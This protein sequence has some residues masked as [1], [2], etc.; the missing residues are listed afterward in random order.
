MFE[1]LETASILLL[2]HHF[3]FN[4]TKR[5]ISYVSSAPEHE[6]EWV[7]VAAEQGSIPGVEQLAVNHADGA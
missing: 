7:A 5:Q 4:Y 2:E 3:W 6:K 1:P